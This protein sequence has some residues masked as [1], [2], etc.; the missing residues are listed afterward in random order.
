[1]LRLFF[2]MLLVCVN[3]SAWADATVLSLPFAGTNTTLTQNTLEELT[4]RLNRMGKKITME[5]SPTA[6]L[7]QKRGNPVLA[8]AL[9]KAGNLQL[10]FNYQQAID[11]LNQALK[12]FE[13]NKPSLAELQK[14]ADVHL[15]L[16]Y[17]YKNLGNNNLMKQE[18][19]TAVRFN[20][21]LTPDELLFPPSLASLVEQAKDHIWSQ[22]HFGK[23]MIES[24]PSD[25][26]IFIN[27]AYKGK[28]PLRLDRYPVGEHHFL[29]RWEDH[30]DY[31][32]ITLRE[33]DNSTL[34][35]HVDNTAPSSQFS[36]SASSKKIRSFLESHAQANINEI[37]GLSLIDQGDKTQITLAHLLNDRIKYDK[38]ITSSTISTKDIAEEILDKLK[39]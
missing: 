20:P 2:L 8:P 15:F 19:E 30:E 6:F 27:G 38:W 10:N 18:M 12:D 23:I 13:S 14:L 35:L 26:D 39:E 9:K 16:A 22:G 3:S 36:L 25:A 33:G 37:I 29:A 5:K 21:S 32:K 24:T 7:P 28:T 1:M 11:V 34:L 4:L 17:L 31:K